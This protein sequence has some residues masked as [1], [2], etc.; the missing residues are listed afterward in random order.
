MLRAWSTPRG[1]GQAVEGT[2]AE[3]QA[4][5]EADQQ[6]R[7]ACRRIDNRVD[8]RGP[9]EDKAGEGGPDPGP[10]EAPPGERIGIVPDLRI[11]QRPAD[12]E[13]VEGV[14]A[15]LAPHQRDGEGGHEQ[16]RRDVDEQD[17]RH[18]TGHGALLIRPRSVRVNPSLSPPAA[19]LKGVVPAPPTP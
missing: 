7:G 10:E 6:D 14:R 8:G 13:A 9:V 1:A 11:V 5:G 3:S 17:E 16:A 19:L 2:E 15:D 12:P 18:E 4:H